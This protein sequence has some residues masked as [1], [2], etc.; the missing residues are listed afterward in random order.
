MEVGQ[1]IM[2]YLSEKGISKTW[3]SKQTGI[4]YNTL[5]G[6]LMGRAKISADNLVKVSNVLKVD[7]N[8]FLKPNSEFQG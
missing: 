7:P 3:L 6:N 4:P 2:Q 1:R 8:I 5:D